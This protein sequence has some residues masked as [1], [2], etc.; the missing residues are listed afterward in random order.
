[1][2]KINKEVLREMLIAN[3][4]LVKSDYV[5]VD[6]VMDE[7][8]DLNQKI[9]MPLTEL[10]SYILRKKYGLLSD[11]YIEPNSKIGTE[12]NLSRDKIADIINV[13]FSKLIFRIKKM[14][15][16]KK[17]LK[18]SSFDIKETEN[19]ALLSLN[20]NTKV[21]NYLLKRNIYTLR[22]LLEYSKIELSKML[23]KKTFEEIVEYVHS[24]GFLFIDE[25]AIA[26]QKNIIAKSSIEAMNNSSIYFINSVKNLDSKLIAKM[27][28]IDIKDFMLK[29]VFVL[30]PNC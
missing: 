4:N 2:N 20:L 12:L 10:E 8:F 17:I 7:L 24:I 21:V 30:E 14:E 1:M 16:D 25:L 3:Y 15:Q 23:P 13:C 9:V 29:N 11:G 27:N 5:I 19:I 6:K 22:E 26:D 18:M 28:P